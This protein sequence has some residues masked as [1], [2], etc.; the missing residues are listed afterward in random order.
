MKN[1]Y[2]LLCMGTLLVSLGVMHAAE[3]SPQPKRQYMRVE[4]SKKRSRTL[5]TPCLSPISEKSSKQESSVNTAPKFVLSPMD[6]L[7]KPIDEEHKKEAT[8]LPAK[9]TIPQNLVLFTEPK[10]FLGKPKVTLDT[11]KPVP[12]HQEIMRQQRSG[13]KYRTQ[14][15]AKKAHL[16][17]LK[18]DYKALLE[19]NTD[20]QKQERALIELRYK[21]A[22]E[23]VAYLQGR[24]YDIGSQQDLDSLKERYGDERSHL[25][26]DYIIR[27]VESCGLEEEVRKHIYSSFIRPVEQLDDRT[28]AIDT[29]AQDLLNLI[30]KL[31]GNCI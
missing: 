12:T 22:D 8:P 31:E 7:P 1:Y 30:K 18:A 6:P 11:T 27:V 10:V 4:H 29:T 21:K 16:K 24:G 25:F 2:H 26:F 5:H 15:K 23:I 13:A 28:P 3:L 20:I 17:R 19:K 9:R 14:Q